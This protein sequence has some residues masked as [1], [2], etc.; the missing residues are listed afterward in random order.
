MKRGRKSVKS[1]LVEALG[2][3]E[4]YQVLADKV[5]DV[6]TIK[7]FQAKVEEVTGKSFCTVSLRS[8]LRKG[9]K[10]GEVRKGTPL[11]QLCLIRRGRPP[12]EKE[13]A[14]E[15]P[16]SAEAV[17]TETVPVAVPELVEAEA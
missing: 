15:A 13:E 8:F 5:G 9:K 7:E 10:A 6:K 17:A 2:Q 3:K 1:Q 14:D 16:V 4:V 11:S 12:V